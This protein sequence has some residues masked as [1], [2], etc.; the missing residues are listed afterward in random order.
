MTAGI[1]SSVLRSQ[2][3]QAT[4]AYRQLI[5]PDNGYTYAEWLLSNRGTRARSTGAALG[6]DKYFITFRR[7]L[8][9]ADAVK[10]QRASAD[11]GPFAGE[12]SAFT[13]ERS[14]DSALDRTSD[15]RAFARSISG[16]RVFRDGFGIRLDEDWLGLA[17][18]QTTASS[19]YGLRPLNTAGYV[20]LSARDNRGLQETSSREA[21]QDTA[22]WRGFNDL[23]QQVVRFAR[24]CQEL[25]RR[26]WQSFTRENLE[27]AVIDAAA[28]PVE[29]SEDIA[30]RSRR[31][32]NL[33]ERVNGA[34]SEVGELSSIVTQLAASASEASQGVWQDHALQRAV[35]EAS[36]RITEV[37]ARLVNALHAVDEVTAL[38]AELRGSAALLG[39]KLSVAEERVSDAWEAVAL[40]LSAEVLS[41]EVDQIADRLRGRSNQMLN[42]LRHVE[43]PDQRA[44]GY[45]E[46]VRASASELAREVGRL[47]PA[48][49]FRRETRSRHRVS[50]LIDSAI[51]YHAQRLR[52][53]NIELRSIVVRDFALVINEGKF[54]QMIDN[55][56]RN[57]EYWVGR[58]QQAGEVESGLIEVC[59]EGPRVLV[60][61]NGPGVLSS[62]EDSLFEPFV[63]AKPGSEGRGLGLFVVA[64]LLDSENATMML[65][66]NRNE[67]GRKY[68]FVLNF[69]NSRIDADD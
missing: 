28:S 9:F 15:Y 4:A 13:Y 17:A 1:Q 64:Q 55:L 44:I 40:G 7:E 60:R 45:A 23:M 57:S 68:I 50:S 2:G 66:E 38:L 22:A 32:M 34:R 36:A 3:A 30:A 14:A 39:E 69:R 6:D 33:G 12:I 49:R 47:N 31:A 20:N 16:V 56:I 24:E 27:P 41:H 63:T 5:E 46:H 52:I 26:N 19:F 8:A 58:A 11:P 18:Q 62:V 29:L 42:H 25:V 35:T 51:A 54:M 37:Q 43:V 61:D 21:F 53:A 10:S 48:L 65:A 67:A 59:V